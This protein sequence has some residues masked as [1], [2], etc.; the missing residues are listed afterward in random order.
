MSVRPWSRPPV[1]RC[2]LFLPSE[3]MD[4]ALSALG[5]LL[6]RTVGALDTGGPLMWAAL[7]GAGALLPRLWQV[8]VAAGVFVGASV[9]WFGL[10]VQ[11]AVFCMVA[12]VLLAG[13]GR[14][15]RLLVHRRD[16]QLSQPAR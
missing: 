7:L 13:I 9:W 16:V 1:D 3:V 5:Y 11:Q 14:A 2:R 15:L 4:S 6:G 12:A 10:G 8:A